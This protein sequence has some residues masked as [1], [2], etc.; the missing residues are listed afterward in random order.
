[1]SHKLLKNNSVRFREGFPGTFPE[2]KRDKIIDGVYIPMENKHLSIIRSLISSE[3]DTFGDPAILDLKCP[4]CE[5]NYQHM[6]EPAYVASDSYDAGW[7]GRGSL[8]TIPMWGECGSKWEIC[9]GFHKGNTAIFIK[10]LDSCQR[11]SN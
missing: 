4:I 11:G 1:M 6:S 7:I 8:I 10:A 5:S 9:L 2:V 3:L